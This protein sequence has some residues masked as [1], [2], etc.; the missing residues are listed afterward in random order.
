MNALIL[1][2]TDHEKV[3]QLFDQIETVR[4]PKAQRKIFQN[5][6]NELELHTSIEEQIFYPACQTKPD[7]KLQIDRSFKEH[8]AVKDQLVSIAK[9]KDQSTMETQLEDLEENVQLHVAEEENELF[10]IVETLF[11][12]DELDTL[13]RQIEEFKSKYQSLAA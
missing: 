5:I 11:T 12:K 4:D 6:K 8:Q 1:L 10:P 3:S 7:L 9:E 13:G 2:K